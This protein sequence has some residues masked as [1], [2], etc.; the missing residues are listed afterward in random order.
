MLVK[1][2]GRWY[3]QKPHGFKTHAIDKTQLF[4][5]GGQHDSHGRLMH[6]L[7]NPFLER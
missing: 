4:P 6:R 3:P 7:V 5:H 1:G 2:E